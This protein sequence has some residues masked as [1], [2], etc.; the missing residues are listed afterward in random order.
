VARTL[1][2]L[3]WPS[4]V[5]LV[6]VL[7]AVPVPAADNKP[8]APDDKQKQVE[9]LEKQLKEL[10]QKLAELKKAPTT[11][12]ASAAAPVEGTIPDDYLSPFKWRSIGPANMGGRVTA[13]A[14]NEADPTT[15]FVATASGG[16]LKTVNNGTTFTHLF[17]NQPTVSIGDVALAPSNPDIVW[18]GTGEANPRNSVS[19]GDGVYKSTDGGKT[20]TNMGLKKTFQIGKIVVHPTNPDVV[21]V[22]ALGRLYGWNEERGVFKTTDGGKTWEKVFYVDDKT[23]CIDLRMDPTNP[24]VLVAAMWGRKR[25]E[26]DGFFPGDKDAPPDQYGPIVTFGPG[27]GL[28][29][30]T[31]AGKSWKK[32]TTGLPT[33]KT[34]RIGLDASPKTKGLLV[35]IIDTERGGTGVATRVYMGVTGETA[36]KAAKITEVTA[37]GPADKAGLK[38]N[39]LVTA[40]D[41]KAVESYEAFTAAFQSKA[42]GDK[43]KLTVK[44]DGKEQTVEV[45]L[46]TRPGE[47]AAAPAGGGTQGGR[48]KGEGGKGAAKGG[49]RKGGGPT[50]GGPTAGGPVL[51]VRLEPDKLTVA[52]VISGGPADKAGLKAGDTITFVDGKKVSTVTE[53]RAALAGKATGDK[54]TVSYV[55]GKEDKT[56]EITLTAVAPGTSGSGTTTTTT[57]AKEA[58]AQAPPPAAAGGQTLPLPGFTPALDFDATEV[59]VAAVTA[60]G[61]AD[62]AGIKVGDII[63]AIE[64]VPVEGFRGFLTALRVGPRAEDPRKAGDKVKVTV[65]QGDK[66]KEV[67]LV[68]VDTPV[69]FGGGGGRGAN[70]NRPFGMGLGGQQPNIQS[71][72]GKDG[73]ETG[74]VYVSKDFGD[75]WERVNSINPRPMYFSVVRVDPNDDKTLYVLCDTPTPIYRSTDGGKTFTNL[76]TA[77]GVHA[78]AHAFWINPKSS[79][80]LIIGCDGGFYVS[81]D[82]GAT[83]DHLNTQALGQ[84]YHVAV[85]NRR[86]YRVYGGLQDNGSW[87]G[88]SHTMRRYGPVNEDWGYVNGGDGFVCR[89][90]PTDPDL[91]YAES[92]GGAI[93]R[94][95]YRTGESRGIRP[96]QVPGLDRYRYNWNTPFILSHHNPS[97]FYSGAQYVFRSVKKGD[98]AKP[99]SPDLTRSPKGS[100]TALSESPRVP[101]ILWAGTDDGNVWVT[102]DD[103]GKWVNV[104]ANVLK[105]GVPGYRCVA[106]LEASREKDGRCYLALDGHRS[107]DDRPYLLVTDDFGATW[108]AIVSN[109]PAFGSTRVLREDIVNPNV[110]YCG[111]E[112]GAWVS[113]NAGAS[114]TKLGAGLPTVAVHEFAQPTVA[115]ELVAA[116]H[117]RSVWVLDI[118][119]IRQ[120]KPEVLK[121][122]V[123]LFT[124]APA[125]RWRTGAGAE[126]PYSQTDRKF[127]GQNPYRGATVEFLLTKKAEK[128]SAKVIDVTGNTIRTF[129]SVPTGAGLH[130]LQWD[131]SGATPRAAAGPRRLAGGQVQPGVYRVVL[132]VDGKE[133]AAPLVVELD[134]N[135]PKDLIATEGGEVEEEEGEEQQAI[136][137]IDD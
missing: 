60:G 98:D 69:P 89:V 24:D 79:K 107:D 22:G 125:V 83:W 119:A 106:S 77:R 70:P 105:A 41:G 93:N 114:W 40:V 130:R 118:N 68:L 47:G 13:L 100:M 4:L 23:G 53:F 46:G 55:R 44:R 1:L 103:G 135:A 49:E 129:P 66:T 81:Y 18:V 73:F 109:L 51:G 36:D 91:V 61:P 71:R 121:A 26:Y 84:F 62:K 90:D 78:D 80:H 120:M 25:D 48:R 127:V 34:G 128:V 7:L 38:A 124:P 8:L 20:F 57:Q 85:D 101:G 2:R 117:G 116:T 6:A 29:K 27:G 58:P 37:D 45:T 102:R 75:T 11:A 54:V 110:L 72:Q 108:K 42:P 59:K 19:Y 52:E 126:S 96:A 111:T 134:P 113:A 97:I 16:L 67:E 3:R 133:F 131:L 94:R 15:Y 76:A 50:A 87:G 5:A 74:G 95:N 115:N 32:L 86:P 63:V 64:G 136:R 30:T 132:T 33:V 43:V 92:Q 56:V 12:P 39:D 65:K 88:P 31:D 28:F 17:D 122:D 112:F 21:Y 14:V 35:A 137:K 104:T 9:D 10:Q 123:T 82:K 99:I